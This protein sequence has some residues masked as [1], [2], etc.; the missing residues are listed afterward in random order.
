MLDQPLPDFFAVMGAD[1]IAYEMNRLDMGD[2]LR[3]QLFQKG[4]EGLLTL[5]RV[6]LPK[7]DSRTGVECGE[8]IHG[9]TAPIFML[10]AVGNSPRVSG[11]RRSE[12]RTRVSGG[13][14]IN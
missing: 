5:A 1:I 3:V 7:D 2:N 11:P 4:D 8:S 6:A 12:T 10:I 9:P 13:V 14:L